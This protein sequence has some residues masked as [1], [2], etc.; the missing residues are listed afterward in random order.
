MI[1]YARIAGFL[2][3][4]EVDIEQRQ[5]SEDG[6][7]FAEVRQVQILSIGEASLVVRAADPI[8]KILEI[9]LHIYDDRGD[10]FDTI[11]LPDPVLAECH[12]EAFCGAPSGARF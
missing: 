4:G 1:P 7:K 11:T 9:E 10:C 6:K 12:Q 8:E 2:H 3:V 5:Q